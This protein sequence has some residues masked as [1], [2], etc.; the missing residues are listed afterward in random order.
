MPTDQYPQL[1]AASL[2]MG[3]PP[4]VLSDLV[5]QLERTYISGG[6]T[7]YR[8]GEPGDGLYAV[9]SGR[10]RVYAE[11]SSEGEQV[12]GEAGLGETVGELSVLHGELRATTVR[13]IRDSRLVKL[14]KSGFDRLLEKHP[15]PMM[16]LARNIAGRLS[17]RGRAFAASKSLRS[18]TVVPC[19]ADVPLRE[20]VHRLLPLFSRIG[21]TVH[22]DRERVARA[23]GDGLLATPGRADERGAMAGVLNDLEGTHRFVVYEADHAA[24]TWTKW[25]VRQADC[26]LLVGSAG[27]NPVVSDIELK[28]LEQQA[29]D[30]PT[31]RTELVLL[32]RDG[33]VRRP[34]TTQWLTGRRVDAHHHVRLDRN[35][36]FERLVRLITGRAV[37]LVLS[38]GAARGFAQIGV[39]RALREFGVPIDYVGGTSMGA[40]IGA[41]LS[42]GWDHDTLVAM[43]KE[44]WID[45][46]PLKDYTL[47]IVGLLSGRKMSR[48]LS[49]MFGEVSIED[50]PV[51]YFCVSS[52][53]S[54]A[55]V[56]V[57]RQG[58]LWRWL[59]ASMSM[60]GVGPPLVHDGELYVDGGVLNNLPVD[61]MGKLCEGSV[62]AVYTSE[63][64]D[65][66]ISMEDLDNLSG[67]QMFWSRCNPF[68]TRPSG[69][70]IFSILVRSIML[71]SLGKLKQVKRQADLFID[72]PVSEFGRFEWK[73]I[74]RLV[75][76]G[77]DTARKKIED[78]QSRRRGDTPTS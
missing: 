64:E 67:W 58:P 71:S 3:L 33:F 15:Q 26:V 49:S 60:P 70:N 11:R 20:F 76:I 8:Q 35:G 62:I 24:P 45:L 51:N 44:H 6:E 66:P 72:P 48:I 16:D 52:N 65:L 28:C 19:G 5:G 68:S 77:Y 78:W 56:A 57:H 63:R 30:K 14:T 34:D 13:A 17:R 36:D 43:N 38:G 22:V 10:L 53:L 46:T 61:V 75:E 21:P 47:P 37:C 42:L 18:I 4:E 40:V 59:R 69:P 54:R 55:Q 31:A 2:F 7:L 23:T 29:S 27:G 1:A 41:Q 74:D 39:I 32:H 25:C 50:L 9:L 73:A 12:I